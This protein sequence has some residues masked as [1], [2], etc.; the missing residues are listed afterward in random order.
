M[1]I[2]PVDFTIETVDGPVSGQRDAF[3]RRPPES[4]VIIDQLEYL[5][6]ERTTTRSPCFFRNSGVSASPKIP[7]LS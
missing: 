1:V 7:G 5:C 4:T 6:L 3:T 2:S